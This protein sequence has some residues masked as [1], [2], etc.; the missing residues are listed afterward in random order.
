MIVKALDFKMH[1]ANSVPRLY[2]S[3]VPQVVPSAGVEPLLCKFSVVGKAVKRYKPLP[4]FIDH[5]ACRYS[6]LNHYYLN[7]LREH[8]PLYRSDVTKGWS[9]MTSPCLAIDDT[10]IARYTIICTI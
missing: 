6:T 1:G 10:K 5:F 8:C 7:N 3:P 4:V 2:L 9:L